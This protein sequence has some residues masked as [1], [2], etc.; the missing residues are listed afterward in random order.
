MA[1]VLNLIVLLPSMRS[2]DRRPTIL[3]IDQAD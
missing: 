1:A 3:A 2:R